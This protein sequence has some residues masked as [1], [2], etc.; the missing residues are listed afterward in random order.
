MRIPN[1]LSGKGPF[2]DALVYVARTTLPPRAELSKLLDRIYETRWVTNFGELH[3]E[4]ESKVAKESGAR[5]AVLCANGTLALYAL[6]KTLDFKGDVLT[7]PFT[8]PATVHS[9]VMAGARPVFCDIDPDDYSLDPAEV[10]RKIGPETSAV[11]GVHVYGNVC[12]VDALDAAA[13]PRGVPVVYDSAHAFKGEF[14]GRRVGSFG[15]AEVFSFHATK[16]FTTIEGGA[17]VTNDESIRRG[18]R[19]LINFGIKDEESVVAVGLNAKMSE[20]HAA[21]GLLNIKETDRI[22][23]KLRTLADIY[24]GRLE[25]VPGIKLQK[26]RPGSTPTNQYMSVEIIAEDFGMDRD[27]LYLALKSENIVARKYF[28]PPAH[29]YECYKNESFSRVSLPNAERAAAG[30]LCLPIYYTLDEKSVE[31]VCDIIASLRA[32]AADVKKK[33]S[34]AR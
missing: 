24:R 6:L 5:Y 33:L 17:V 28:Y 14:N 34:S 2:F 7:T 8:F 15:R 25:R 19:H 9:I 30:I 20:F 29:K 23:E 1:I 18:V 26:I 13:S 4:L 11:L 32:N 27:S 31:G 22:L 10:A 12:D 16:L 3:N 21:V